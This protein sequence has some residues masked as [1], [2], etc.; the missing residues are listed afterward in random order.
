MIAFIVHL[1][2][3]V[4]MMSTVGMERSARLVGRATERLQG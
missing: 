2:V 4:V 3:Y 1:K